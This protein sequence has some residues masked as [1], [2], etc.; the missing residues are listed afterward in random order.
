MVRP[1]CDTVKCL[2]WMEGNSV[3][4]SALAE[5]FSCDLSSVRRFQ[6]AHEYTL[7]GFQC[8]GETYSIVS[9][10]YTIIFA[11]PCSRWLEREIDID[12]RT[13]TWVSECEEVVVICVTCYFVTSGIVQSIGDFICVSV[14]Q[15]YGLFIDISPSFVTHLMYKGCPVFFAVYCPSSKI[16]NPIKSEMVIWLLILS[17]KQSYTWL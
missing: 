9:Q 13:R 15:A 1:E 4:V 16:S 8:S 12:S 14:N 17:Y 2:V 6:I 11:S 3:S 10:S 5:Y 7:S